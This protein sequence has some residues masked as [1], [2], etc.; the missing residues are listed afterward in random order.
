M[1]DKQHEEMSSKTVVTMIILSIIGFILAIVLAAKIGQS[2]RG[3]PDIDEAT[4]E[5]QTVMRIKPVGQVQVGEPSAPVAAVAAAGSEA[6]AT[7]LKD[8]K[9]VF[10]GTCMGCHGGALPAAPKFG[11]KAAWA[12][13]I[14]QGKDTLYKHALGGFM[15]VNGG[16]MP[17]KGGNDAL[18]EAEVKAAV[19]YMVDAAK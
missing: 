16:Q 12:P 4:A 17:P 5:D 19:D 18:A 13:R 9:T 1:S 7:P 3:A 10:E 6:A 15:G 11:D 2:F 8:G 14:A